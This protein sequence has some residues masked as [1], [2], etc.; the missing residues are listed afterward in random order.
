MKKFAVSILVLL[1]ILPVFSQ[2][3]TPKYL[4]K[5]AAELPDGSSWVESIKKISNDLYKKTNGEI[6]IRIYAG[7]VMGDQNTVIN[8]IKIGQLSGATFSSGGLGL[9]YKDFQVVGFP[10][11]FRSYDEYDYIKNKMTDFF[12]KEFEK[13]GFVLLAFSEVGSIYL[14]SKNKVYTVDTLRK[15]KPFLVSGD[16]VSQAL[17]DEIKASPVPLQV[18]DVLT[19]LQTGTIDTVFSSPYTLIVL[20]WFTKVK[21]MANFPITFMIGAIMVDKK[22]FYS[23]PQ[24]YQKEMKQMFK[25]TFDNLNQQVRDDNKKALETLKKN[26]IIIL[27]VSKKDKENFYTACNNVADRLTE[28]EYSRDL[29]NTI[30]RHVEEYRKITKK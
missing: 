3:Q 26:G 21:Y 27:E 7:G 9:I 23:M 15:S 1:L 16:T 13:R 2:K 17:F 20:Q 18:Q 29:Y 25:T 5:I 19:G 30:V 6:G 12:E 14:F 10:S 28:K 4:F 24:S 22:L 11:I 8:K